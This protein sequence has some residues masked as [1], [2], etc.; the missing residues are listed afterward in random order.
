MD[1]TLLFLLFAASMGAALWNRR[2]V[3]IGIALLA[4]VLCVADYLH[5]ATDR[6]PLSF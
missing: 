5:H 4:L 6:L 3:A 2:A 1:Q